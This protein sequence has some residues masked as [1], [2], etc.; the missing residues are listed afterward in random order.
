MEEN[1]QRGLINNNV[2]IKHSQ[3]PLFFLKG[4]RHYSEPYSMNCLIGTEI[5]GGKIN[6]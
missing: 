5:P 4:Y 6:S 1:S 3:G 2:A